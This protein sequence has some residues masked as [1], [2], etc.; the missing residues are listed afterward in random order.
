MFL[1][2]SSEAIVVPMI[3]LLNETTQPLMMENERKGYEMNRRIIII[4]IIQIYRTI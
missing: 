3:V 1:F 4:G 2:K